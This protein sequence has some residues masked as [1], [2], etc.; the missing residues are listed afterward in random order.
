LS[1]NV[2]R[3]IISPKYNSSHSINDLLVQLEVKFYTHT[4]KRVELCSCDYQAN[5]IIK[6]TMLMDLHVS[7]VN[8]IDG[9]QEKWLND[10][11]RIGFPGTCIS[12]QA[13]ATK[14]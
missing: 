10:L 14:I 6:I 9:Y 1:F 13:K 8:I 11:N 3:C 12:L 7:W 5:L 2:L 4:K